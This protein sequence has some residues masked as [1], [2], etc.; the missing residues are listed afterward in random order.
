MARGLPK[1]KRRLDLKPVLAGLFSS[2]EARA[3]A[4][5]AAIGYYSHFG[6][7]RNSRAGWEDRHRLQIASG[8][9]RAL[10][11]EIGKAAVDLPKHKADPFSVKTNTWIVDDI[12]VP[13]HTVVPVEIG[14]NKIISGFGVG[15]LNW[16]LAYPSPVFLKRLEVDGL[17]CPMPPVKNYYHLM[18]DNLLPTAFALIRHKDEIKG[19]PVTF[20][21]RKAV[22]A[23]MR[24]AEALTHIG[25]VTRVLE[26]GPTS[27]VKAKAG[28]LAFSKHAEGHFSHGYWPGD[29]RDVLFD[30][31]D[32]VIPKIETAE[33][34]YV[35]RTETRIRKLLNEA[36]FAA[37]LQQAGFRSFAA[38]WGNFD[39]QFRTFSQAREIV[40]VHGAGLTN[41]C[42]SKP[43]TVVTEIMPGNAR[44]SHFLQ[45][46]AEQQLDYRLYF[47]GNEA[48]HQ[49]FAIDVE[50][51]MN[52]RR[53]TQ[54]AQLSMERK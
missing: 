21:V 28:F 29:E 42:W 4:A 17:V 44:R 27:H 50:D 41:V 24:F 46:A 11:D 53:T 23:T 8:R 54:A 43:R 3:P 35:P 47:A 32:K 14:T 30:A 51:F 12:V 7:P 13:G 31:L 36:A 38:R 34:I 25:I 16:G 19:V 49:N 18:I 48:R 1:W 26:I 2:L 39:E 22:S 52:A 40:A 5:T 15:N 9:Y 20:V 6:A 33:R 45:I 37:A 10:Y